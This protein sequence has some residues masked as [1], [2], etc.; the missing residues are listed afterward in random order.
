M[1]SITVGSLEA[2]H[3]LLYNQNDKLIIK[4]SSKKYAEIVS[5]KK[6]KARDCSPCSIGVKSGKV[7]VNESLCR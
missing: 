6:N 7:F 1:A 2:C 3:C 5:S 4:F